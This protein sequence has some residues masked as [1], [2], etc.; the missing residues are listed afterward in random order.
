VGLRHEHL[1][2]DLKVDDTGN[3]GH[4]G[5]Q[6]LRLGAKR[7]EVLAEDLDRDL[8]PD[9]GE[10]VVDAVGNRLTDVHADAGDRIEARAD[11]VQDLLTAGL[12]RGEFDFDFGRVNALRV[13]G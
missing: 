5:A 3:F 4:Q 1:L 13:V 6:L 8:R 7:G 12:R 2:L 10:K 11:I 9:T